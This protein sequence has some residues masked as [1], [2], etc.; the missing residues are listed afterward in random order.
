MVKYWKHLN[1]MY[2]TEESRIIEHKLPW[3]SQSKL[4]MFLRHHFY[5]MQLISIPHGLNEFMGV[6]DARLCKKQPRSTA[7]VAKKV[8]KDVPLQIHES[9]NCPAH[10]GR[11]VGAEARFKI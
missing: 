7:L 9:I 4:K 3:R 6:L 1:L 8:R 2:L 10:I 11:G 5:G